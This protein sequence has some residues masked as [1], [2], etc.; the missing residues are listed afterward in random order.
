MA[1]AFR[2]FQGDCLELMRFI[3]D[4]SVDLVL[5]DLPYGT[6]AC[7]WDAV[8]PFEP[9]WREYARV[10]RPFAAVV[11]TSTQPFTTALIASNLPQFKYQW[12]WEKSRPSGFAQAKN[13]PLKSHEDVCVFSAGVTVHASQSDRRMPYNPQGLVQLA[14]PIT[15]EKKSW[16]DSSF[17]KRPSHKAYQQTQTGY[18]RSVLRFPSES[19]TD[20]PTQKPVPLFEYLIRTYTNEGDT[21]L[22]N[23]MGSGTTGVACANTGRRFIGIEQDARYFAIAE[24]RIK[25]AFDVLISSSGVDRQNAIGAFA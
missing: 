14:E 10:L 12:V 19:L 20:H 11:L 16:S 24:Q 21:V 25:S 15:L 22:D 17:S 5:A 1:D 13:M 6:T 7:A 23:T 8:I 3:P 2:L 9:L 18:P 4:G